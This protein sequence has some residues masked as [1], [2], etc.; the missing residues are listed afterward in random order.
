MFST[1]GGRTLA[2]DPASNL[3]Y[4]PPQNTV[5]PDMMMHACNSRF[6][7]EDYDLRS[8]RATKLVRPH[9]NK[10][11]MSCTCKSQLQGMHR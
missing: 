9:L 2:P 11:G 10:Q 5:E 4:P 3:S 6:G 7:W 1:V 8:P